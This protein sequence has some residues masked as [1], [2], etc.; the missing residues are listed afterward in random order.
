M[1]KRNI[2]AMSLLLFAF[3]LLVQSCSEKQVQTTPQLGKDKVEDVIAA[4]TLSL[5]HI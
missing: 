1:K 2:L 5:K 4:M 3:Q